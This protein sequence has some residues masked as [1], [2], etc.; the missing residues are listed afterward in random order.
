MFLK[1]EE[2]TERQ[3]MNAPLEISEDVWAYRY[4]DRGLLASRAVGQ[5]VAVI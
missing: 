5:E 4:L 3:G 2:E 1:K